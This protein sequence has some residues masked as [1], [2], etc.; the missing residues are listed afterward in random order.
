MEAPQSTT[1]AKTAVRIPE[2]T[3]RNLVLEKNFIAAPFIADI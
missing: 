1:T 2:Y 3:V